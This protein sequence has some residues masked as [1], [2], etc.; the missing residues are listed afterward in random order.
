MKMVM[1]EAL[2]METESTS[3]TPVKLYRT[4]RRYNP[5]DGHFHIRLCENL[6]SY[7]S[8]WISI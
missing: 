5:E 7:Y 2:L 8:G 3:E 6:K 1:M 4:I